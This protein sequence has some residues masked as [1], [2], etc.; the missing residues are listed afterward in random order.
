MR[1][2]RFLPVL[3][4][5][6]ALPLRAGTVEEEV[7]AADAA[8]VLATLRGDA[9]R[10]T[11]LLSDSLTYGHLDGRVQSKPAFLAAVRSKDLK[12]E[13][14]DYQETKIIPVSEDVAIMT[15]RTH[16]KASAGTQ[17][18]EFAIRF[19]A[20]WRREDGVWHLFAYQSTQLPGPVAVSPNKK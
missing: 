20:V 18:V 1:R 12:Y 11:R 6:L 5:L 16:L 15:G 7:R 13:V 9:D 3:L 2:L 4:V 17:R 14:Y 19:L 8:R 10:L